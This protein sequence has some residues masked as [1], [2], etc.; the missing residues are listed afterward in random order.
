MSML[1]QDSIELCGWLS[2]S[3]LGIDLLKHVKWKRNLWC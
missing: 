2:R 3:G 1:S